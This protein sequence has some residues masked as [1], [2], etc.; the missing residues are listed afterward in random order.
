MSKAFVAA[1]L[2]LAVLLMTG[3][4]GPGSESESADAARIE[5]LLEEMTLAEKVGQVMVVA[6]GGPSFS[7]DLKQTLQDVR[8]GG[9]ILYDV[10][11]NIGDVRQVA[12]LVSEIQAFSLDSGALPLFIT[13]DQEGGLVCRITAGVTVFPG[14]MTLGAAGSEE[15]AAFRSGC[16]C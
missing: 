8:P 6:F 15:S 14:N 11:G 5:S 1:L 13:A 2:L 7:P 4:C 12:G 10:M 9:V 3:G 16:W